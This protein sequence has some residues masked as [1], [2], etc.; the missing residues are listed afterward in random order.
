MYDFYDL[1]FENDYGL[2]LYLFDYLIDAICHKAERI[3][4]LSLN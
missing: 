3:D 2:K 1:L 4:E